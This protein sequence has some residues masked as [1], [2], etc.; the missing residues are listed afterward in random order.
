MLSGDGF[1]LF[2]RRVTWSLITLGNLSMSMNNVKYP[3]TPNS[4]K[5]SLASLRSESIT[6]AF[7]RLTNKEKLA[8]PGSSNKKL[9]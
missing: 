5:A 2:A 6:N 7:F 8:E 4:F 1:T 3:E 9:F